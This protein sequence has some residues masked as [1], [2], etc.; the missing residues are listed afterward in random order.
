MR[1][2]RSIGTTLEMIKWEHSFLP[3]PLGLAAAVLAAQ[4]IPSARISQ[5]KSLIPPLPR[6]FGTEAIRQIHRLPDVGA[7]AGVDGFAA[8]WVGHAVGDGLQRDRF[9][10]GE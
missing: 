3:L 6:N 8:E 7:D 1:L 5:R 10:D 4:G 9:G 2:F